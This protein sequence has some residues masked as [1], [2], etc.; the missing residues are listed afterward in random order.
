MVTGLS[1]KLSD[2]IS[3]DHDFSFKTRVLISDKL[4]E[5]HLVYFAQFSILYL[6]N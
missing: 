4:F 6:K 3:E 1:G 5:G 2:D